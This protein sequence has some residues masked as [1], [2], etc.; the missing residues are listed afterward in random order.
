MQLLELE[1]E[2]ELDR[3]YLFVNRTIADGT[4]PPWVVPVR[5]AKLFA[6]EPLELFA[7]VDLSLRISIE[8]D[9]K[10]AATMVM[11]EV[12]DLVDLEAGTRFDIVMRNTVIGYGTVRSWNERTIDVASD[13]RGDTKDVYGLG[14]D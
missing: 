9:E 1:V 6:G 4:P 11:R 12:G 3:P 2:I 14:E 8:A 13:Y 5:F 7:E 10:V